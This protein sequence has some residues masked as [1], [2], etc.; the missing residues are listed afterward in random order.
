MAEEPPAGAIP[1]TNDLVFCLVN[2]DYKPP[3]TSSKYIYFCTDNDLVYTAFFA[4]FGPLNLGLACTFCRQLTDAVATAT[5]AGKKVAYYACGPHH[6]SNSA[7][8]VC[9]YQIFVLG[10]SAAEAYAPFMGKE[11]FVPFRDAAF[12]LNTFPLLV[13]GAFAFLS[14]SPSLPLS[15]S[16]PRPRFPPH[17]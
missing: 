16:H 7:V 9:A 12:C 6:H 1:I 2:E 14:S 11:P 4:D 10:Y 5:A 3:C 15:P 8:L 17:S 13:L